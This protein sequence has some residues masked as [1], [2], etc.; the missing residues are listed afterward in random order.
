MIIHALSD[1][2]RHHIEM[3]P[4]LT[5]GDLLVLAGDY[6]CDTPE[7]NFTFLNWVKKLAP[8]YKLGI[9]MVGGNHDPE[10][11]DNFD[12]IKE[13]LLNHKIYLLNNEYL[14]L[15]GLKIFGSPNI[16]TN[17]KFHRNIYA[18]ARNMP[19]LTEVYK[20]IPQNLDLLIT[21]T[22]PKFILDGGFGSA[23]LYNAI[24]KTRPKIN[25]FG[26]NHQGFG[27]HKKDHMIDD[28]KLGETNFFNVAI[29]GDSLNGPYLP[30]VIHYENENLISFIQK[31][32][33]IT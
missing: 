22:P 7:K 13:D 3:T 18:F 32:M 24:L 27:H 15:G 26:H 9:V 10:I 11:E 21:H 8:L 2:H 14:E 23:A 6:D 20:A 25:I 19:Q 12:E 4:Y 33:D 28:Y 16:E 31:V 30:T 5:G 17:S 1:I 29:L